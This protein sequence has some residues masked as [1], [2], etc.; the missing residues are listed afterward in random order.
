MLKQFAIYILKA[1]KYSLQIQRFNYY[2]L[3]NDL[4]II[5]LD[6]PGNKWEN[7]CIKEAQLVFFFPAAT[8]SFYSNFQINSW[9]R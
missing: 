5:K 6:L 8:D 1:V 9:F 2:R 7:A 4:K 3:N